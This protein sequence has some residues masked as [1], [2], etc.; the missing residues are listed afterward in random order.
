MQQKLKK[1]ANYTVLYKVG[2]YVCW[3]ISAQLK[4][5]FNVGTSY[6]IANKINVGFGV[7]GS[8]PENWYKQWKVRRDCLEKFALG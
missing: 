5:V 4:N 2:T 1:F 6:Y 3:T 8:Q 7:A